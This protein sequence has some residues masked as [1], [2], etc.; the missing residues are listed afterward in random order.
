MAHVARLERVL[1]DDC[2]GARICSELIAQASYDEGM[3]LAPA[4]LG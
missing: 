2:L 4:G 1:D 3:L